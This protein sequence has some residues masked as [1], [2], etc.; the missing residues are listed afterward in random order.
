VIDGLSALAEAP[1]AGSGAGRPAIAQAEWRREPRPV[2]IVGGGPAGLAV[3][4]VLGRYGVPATVL[5]RSD[6]VAASWRTYP[7]KLRLRTTRR[8]SGLP[9][10]RIPGDRGRWVTRDDMVRYLERYAAFHQIEINTRTEVERIDHV[11]DSAEA[12]ARWLLRTAAGERVFADTV[13]VATGYSHTPYVP[14]WPGRDSFTGTILHARDYRDPGR[15]TGRTVLIAGAGN[16]GTDIAVEVAQ[17]GASGVWLAVRTPPHIIPREVAGWPAQATGILLEHLPPR[18]IDRAGRWMARLSGP[19]LSAYGL[20]RPDDGLHTRLVRDHAVPVWDSGLVSAVRSADIEV[21]PAVLGF[22]GDEAHLADG[23]V[24][25]P[26]V[27]IAATG[28]RQGL[29]T[30]V[31]HL[32]VLDQDGRPKASGGAAAAPGLY[33]AGYTLSLGGQLHE[34]AREARRIG[35]AVHQETRRT[36]RDRLAAQRLPS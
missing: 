2:V 26:D 25:T 23:S 10:L 21:V 12:D 6:A 3:A 8:L 28:Y 36:G 17:A 35:R 29:E 7:D 13:V 5:E 4:A 27:V 11:D 22:T 19:D 20:P 33:F 14:D 16:S 15:Y 24:I 31:G 32:G 1:H 34:I 30:M 9:G 18:A